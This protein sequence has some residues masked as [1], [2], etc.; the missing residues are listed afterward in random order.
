[1]SRWRFAVVRALRIRLLN[2][3]DD[4]TSNLEVG[5]LAILGDD[6]T[7]HARITSR[8]G[9]TSS[10]HRWPR[11]NRKIL[12]VAL[13]RLRFRSIVAAKSDANR[14]ANSAN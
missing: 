9:V 8:F 14:R 4:T 6:L 13:L 3:R 1:M 2:A 12:N 11:L 10:R 5:R 7:A